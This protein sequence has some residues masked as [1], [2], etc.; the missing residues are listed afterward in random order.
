RA[1]SRQ[2]HCASDRPWLS[3][4]SQAILTRCNATSGGKGR[5]AAGS[6]LVAEAGQAVAPEPFGPLADVARAHPAPLGGV[7]QGQGPFE[8]QE[9][10]APAGQAGGAFGGALP[11]LDFRS[12]G[13]GRD[14]GQGRFA[15]A[16]GDTGGSRGVAMEGALSSEDRH[17]QAASSIR[18]PFFAA[19]YLQ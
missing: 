12:V 9:D 1:I 10:A 15:A 17:D 19:L 13:G 4:R 5:L 11:A 6:G 14:D 8:Q 16:H 7:L 3:G 2:S 18:N